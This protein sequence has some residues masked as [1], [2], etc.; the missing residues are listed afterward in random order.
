MSEL[1]NYSVK[2]MIAGRGRE[3][4]RGIKAG[5]KGGGNVTFQTFMAMHLKE[6]VHDK[7]IM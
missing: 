4:E 1:G 7:G 3:K 2:G 6:M 5:R